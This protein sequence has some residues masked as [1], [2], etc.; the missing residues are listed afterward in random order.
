MP[1]TKINIAAIAATITLSACGGHDMKSMNNAQPGATSVVGGVGFNNVD[2]MFAQG[3]VPHH[4]QAVEMAD[5]ALN[6]S[7]AA[8]SAVKGLATQIKA[9]QD[10]EITLMTGWLTAWGQPLAMAADHDMGEMDGMMSA[11]E[12]GSLA[13]A[14]GADFDK[15]WITMMIKHH[16]GA[17]VMA[18]QVIKGGANPDVAKLAD[19]IIAGQTEE[20]AEMTTLLGS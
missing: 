6:P 7:A 18:E 5:Q 11:A 1:C 8:S 13:K 16:Q 14:T 19:A 3:M 10:P 2:V 4:R 20:I 17:V 15:Q 9:A 12:M